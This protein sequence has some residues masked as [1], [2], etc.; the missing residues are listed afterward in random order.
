MAGITTD[1]FVI[2]RLPGVITELQN[3]AVDVFQDLV[4]EGDFV[5]TSESTTIGR[6]IGLVSPS[7]S[8]L[9]E[10]AQQDYAAF[11]PNTATGIALDNLVA[12]GAISRQEETSSVAQVLLTGTNGTL[13]NAGATIGSD[14]SIVQ[15]ELISS[16]ALSPT[17]ASGAV[18][19]VGTVADSTNY[20][21]TYTTLSSSN[22]ITYTSGIGATTA[23][24]LS[25]LKSAIDA[26]HPTLSAT[27]VGTTLDVQRTD[28]FS[29][30]TFSCSSNLTIT[31]VVKLGE[32]QA[33]TTGPI[34]AEANT[35]TNI[36]TP[37]LGW[38]SATN[39]LAASTGT[40]KE[41]D[42]E[43]RERFRNTKFERASNILEALYSALISVD[44]VEEV[45]IYEN[46]TDVTDVNGVPPHSFMSIVLGGVSFDI[47]NTIWENKPMGIMSYGDTV[48]QIT[49]SQGFS[50]D[51]GFKIPDP[52]QVYVSIALTTDSLFPATGEDDIKSAII[53]YFE[54][55]FNI[56]DDV[57]YSRL[58]TPINS[59][60]GH[61]VD[62]L[63]IGTSPSP[64]GTSNI[65]IAF[66]QI[67]TISSA[68]ITISV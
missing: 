16:V 60:A 4:P 2:R 49:D 36:L 63:F 28:E 47:A 62:S 42:E 33:T 61:Q 40:N 12:L 68:N 32:V 48:V 13:I 10:A 18:F 19:T 43:L 25:G 41:T 8:D 38:D 44:T 6:L 51:I 22:T 9:W 45:R 39:P 65:S 56:G 26:S 54:N 23:S 66:D 46:D 27:V 64:V 29:V 58:Y 52:A 1:G 55:N 30:V 5:D 17:G 59:V 3:K 53:S 15:W 37:Q 20:T 57:V 50:H 7:L 24:I 35:L 21:I 34:E 31:K 14:S 11:D 67:A